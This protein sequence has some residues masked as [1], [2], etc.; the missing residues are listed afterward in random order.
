MDR[1]MKGLGTFT[2]L[3]LM[4]LP[5]MASGEEKEEDIG[6]IL[7][8]A[9]G[10]G[11]LTDAGVASARKA[12]IDDALKQAVEQARGVMVQSET[13]VKDFV[14]VRDEILSNSKGF[15]KRYEILQE[16]KVEA[17]KV[18]RVEVQA[19]VLLSDPKTP[20]ARLDQKNFQ[21]KVPKILGEVN[22][23]SRRTDEVAKGA[24]AREIQG[25]RKEV[26]IDLDQRYRA[27]I[28]LL[29]SLQAPPGKEPQHERL[30]EA[31]N[32]KAK[33]TFLYGR[34]SLKEQ[35]GA[36]LQK[37]NQMNRNANRI[38]QET[39]K[40]PRDRPFEPAKPAQGRP[41]Q[42]DKPSRS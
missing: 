27:M 32:L 26:F 9:A 39:K 37:A 4:L 7:V 41:P 6:A 25:F 16:K 3:I 2:L 5:G 1:M 14:T 42:P 35:D 13:L 10:V 20:P 38:L 15:V 19:A 28:Q 34:Y 36:I 11:P 22:A 33:A 18:Y 24:N 31:V 12:A 29:N 17:D 23:L 21:T 40:P 30:K 8:K